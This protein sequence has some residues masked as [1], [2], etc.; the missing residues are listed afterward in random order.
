M[1]DSKFSHQP[2]SDQGFPAQTPKNPHRR[3]STALHNVCI[4]AENNNAV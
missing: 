1:L 3:Q 4:S 2:E